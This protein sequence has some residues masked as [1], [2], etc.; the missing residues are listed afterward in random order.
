MMADKPSVPPSTQP[1]RAWLA[2]TRLL[3]GLVVVAALCGFALGVVYFA[4]PGL[5]TDKVTA[6]LIQRAE[7]RGIKLTIGKTWFEPL[8]A[9]TLDDVEVRDAAHPEASPV[10]RIA[11]LQIK[12]EIDGVLSPKLYLQTILLQA[13]DLYLRREADGSWNVQSVV[14]RL[15]KPREDDEEAH[16]G[17]W[18]KYV[19]KHLPDVEMRQLRA[20]FDDDHS[21]TPALLAGLDLHHL[22]VSDAALTLK[23]TSAVAETQNLVLQASARVAGMA[24]AVQLS[25]K[26]DRPSDGKELGV[27]ELTLRLPGEMAVDMGGWRAQVGHLTART[28]GSIALGRVQ[29]AQTTG[30]SQFA[31]DIQ[32]IAIKLSAVPGPEPVLPEALRDKI[33]AFARQMLRR[34]AEVA[35]EEPVIVGKRQ[36]K[37]KDTAAEDED[38]EATRELSLDD[39][40]KAEAAKRAAKGKKIKEDAAAKEAAAKK[41]DGG[42]DGAI[43]RNGLAAAFTQGADKLERNLA[44]LR[45][46]M[47]AIP[48]PLITVQRGRARFSDEQGAA[49]GQARELSDFSAKLQRKAGED[50]ARLELAFHTPGRQETNQVEG[51]VDTK[52]GDVELKMQLEH[53]PLAAY[54]ALLPPS[55]TPEANGAVRDAALTLLYTAASGQLTLEGHGK[56][57]HLDAEIARISRQK[58]EDLVVE[59]KGKLAIDLR[60]EELKLDD[61]EVIVG[62]THAVIQATVKRFRTAPAFNISVKVPTVP[63][64]DVIRSAPRGFAPMLDGMTCE[65][66]LSAEAK[67]V[68]DTANMNSM[69]LEWE[70][71]LGNVHITSMG[72]YIRFDIFDAPFE[73]HARQ[74]DG[75]LYTFVTG[76]GADLWVPM[77]GI[78]NNFIKVLTTT[79]DGGFFGHK[80]FSWESFKNAAIENLKRGRFVRGA[81]TIT[82]QLVKNLF[83]VER[84]KT[85]SR[86]V[87]EAIVTW[88]IERSLSKQQMMALYL[89]IIELGPKIYG[90]KAASQHYFNRPPSDLTLLQAIWLGNIVPNPRAF[91]GQYRNGKVSDGTKTT[92][93]WIAGVMLNRNKI[94]EDELKQL[95]DCSGVF[96]TEAAPQPD[97][98]L[99]HEGDPEL[100]VAPQVPVPPQPSQ[101]PPPPPILNEH[102]TQPQPDAP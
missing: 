57:E 99:G 25:G 100:D 61:A 22:R 71:A 58:L 67:L 39:A 89:N 50:V 62:Q 72:K 34:V 64:Q 74:K 66:Q 3:R 38:D 49:G 80:G 55:L 97:R 78:S 68:L 1:T 27:G 102:H 13:P 77:D 46:A 32:E 11:R 23:N 52:T 48:V 45:T 41:P 65:G 6:G 59:A 30:T 19:S 43:V 86:K 95:G 56:V 70:P 24:D 40:K 18:R 82:Q 20:G 88:Q 83:F 16:G 54:A 4:L 93:C 96:A 26:L 87:Q 44:K 75:T 17:G 84:E 51:R 15:L 47:S 21:K 14:D 42:A 12:Y 10:A 81:S 98:G 35:I 2:R 101:P 5:M 94:T 33:P 60:K 85:I 92:L 29:L 36:E 79:E 7:K 53:L 90:I 37:T 31:L 9:L 28:D 76:P 8:S 63:C 69:K 73:H 91:Y